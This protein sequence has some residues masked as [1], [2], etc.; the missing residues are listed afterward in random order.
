MP[1]D[2]ST[3]APGPMGWVTDYDMEPIASRLDHE[4]RYADD[5]AERAPTLVARRA[6]QSVVN[7]P[8]LNRV[9]RLMSEHGMEGGY[10]GRWLYRTAYGRFP[11]WLRQLIGS[12]VASGGMRAGTLK[13]YTDILLHGQ[14]ESAFGT[15]FSGTNNV[16]MFAPFSYRAGRKIGGLRGGDGSFC[17]A[18][19]E[20]LMKYGLLPC[21]TPGLGSD[22]DA[23]PEP[24]DMR[25]YRRWGDSDQLLDKYANTAKRYVLIESERIRD[26]D[27]LWTVLTE[28]R[29][30]AM[31]CSGWA[32]KPD[33]VHPS[34]TIDGERVWMYTR[35]RRNSWAHNMSIT[36]GFVV[37]GVK[38][39][40]V[41][42]SWGDDAHRNG[43]WFPVRLSEVG[44]WLREAE[45]RTH[46]DF[47]LRDPDV[48]IGW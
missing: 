40:E 24:Q 10:S 35:D 19:I 38:W 27:Q 28:H 3:S 9:N 33:A 2:K 13:T 4:A 1:S 44:Q 37:D 34:W 43:D 39:V 22:T 48:P 42:N 36:G 8:L 7:Q 23:F 20:G 11:S 26:A 30:T 14:P 5:L 15:E 25:T 41:T 6:A 17:G 21:D 47:Q 46:G 31:I 45:C 32:F 16:N 18:H 29:K 12:C